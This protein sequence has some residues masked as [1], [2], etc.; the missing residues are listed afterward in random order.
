M[1]A[2]HR[3]PQQS[4]P[5]FAFYLFLIVFNSEPFLALKICEETTQVCRDFRPQGGL[6]KVGKG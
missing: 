1:Q 5:K 2:T 3:E 4:T 6:P